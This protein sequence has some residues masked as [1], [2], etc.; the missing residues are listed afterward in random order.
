MVSCSGHG[1]VSKTFLNCYRSKK[2]SIVFRFGQVDVVWAKAVCEPNAA[3]KASMVAE[4]QAL[5]MRQVAARENPISPQDLHSVSSGSSS[6]GDAIA[7]NTAQPHQACDEGPS[8]SVTPGGC[9]TKEQRCAECGETPIYVQSIGLPTH[10]ADINGYLTTSQLT[11]L[12]MIDPAITGHGLNVSD[13][14]SAG[15]VSYEAQQVN[16]NGSGFVTV[17]VTKQLPMKFVQAVQIYDQLARTAAA[18]KTS[19]P[20]IRL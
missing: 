6:S 19:P 11:A 9:S 18:T 16:S 14:Y 1:A 15:K 10:Y 4:Q 17:K 13:L 7:L 12:Q 8:M 3:Y 2:G 20:C 5:A